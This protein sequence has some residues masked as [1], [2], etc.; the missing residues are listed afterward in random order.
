MRIAALLLFASP[1][2]A[3]VSGELPPS[4]RQAKSLLPRDA[5][6]AVDMPAPPTPVGKP[7]E[8][9][10]DACLRRL[11]TGPLP[12]PTPPPGP[13]P[14]VSGPR[15]AR[16]PG[17]PSLDDDLSRDSLAEAARRTAAYWDARSGASVSIDGRSYG[18]AALARAAEELAR[19]A[20]SIAD[21]AALKAALEAR[22][23]A[24]ESLADS[25]QGKVTGYF[26]PTIPLVPAPG[27][28]AVLGRP[29]DLGR[30]RPY[31]TALE[32]WSGALKRRHLE[33]YGTPH[34]ADLLSL[35]IEGSGWGDLGGGR[36]VF[37]SYDGGNGYAFRSVSRSLAY[38][39]VVPKVLG[40]PELLD[41][42]RSLPLEREKKAVSLNPNFVFFKAAPTGAPTGSTGVRLIGGRSIA[43]DPARVP[44]GLPALLI[45]KQE[46]ADEAGRLTGERA[47]SRLVFAHDIGGAIKG[48]AR[49]DLYWGAGVQAEA[50]ANRQ[51][52]AGRLI[53]LAP[54]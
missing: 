31:L 37:L 1:V 19:L 51:M 38:C 5:A 14:P 53:V 22:F 30:R 11:G 24:Y 50:E 23:D 2:A 40:Q 46:V 44:L 10:L 4:T 42:L 32:I 7:A 9:P 33:L 43:V 52:Q 13:T 41:W 35:Q 12:T 34:P 36:R 29:S 15:W 27:P 16:L 54:K 48:G 20:E 18:A 45:S 26:T 8:D 47:F 3:A 17:L 21:P 39:G 49:V 6:P 28:A 25:G